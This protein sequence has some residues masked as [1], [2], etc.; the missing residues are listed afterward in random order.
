MVMLEYG[1]IGQDV[2]LKMEKTSM[3]F[4]SG[5]RTDIRKFHGL[6]IVSMLDRL[7]SIGGH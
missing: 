5:F 7:G 2:N 3:K 6:F 1:E 4:S